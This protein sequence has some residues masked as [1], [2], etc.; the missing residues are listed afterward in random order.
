MDVG[1]NHLKNCTGDDKLYFFMIV[2]LATFFW[3]LM[4]L[5]E[6]LPDK[7]IELHDLEL[8]SSYHTCILFFWI[9]CVFLGFFLSMIRGSNITTEAVFFLPV[10]AVGVAILV[11]V[12]MV[13]IHMSYEFSSTYAHAG[14]TVFWVFPMGFLS[15]LAI[16]LGKKMYDVFDYFGKCLSV[17]KASK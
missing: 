11:Y 13:W 6:I 7:R 5:F 9:F 8:V 4:K 1:L 14:Y 2:V 12:L 16:V 3:C 15:F 17:Y 10:K